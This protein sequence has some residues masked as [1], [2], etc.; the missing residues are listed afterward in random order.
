MTRHPTPR[1]HL[2]RMVSRGR[3]RFGRRDR[4]FARRRSS[5]MR[6]IVV[7]LSLS[8]FGLAN[9]VA[10]DAPKSRMPLVN[11]DEWHLIYF[12]AKPVGYVHRTVRA[13]RGGGYQVIDSQKPALRFVLDVV[14]SRVRSVEN[15]A[16]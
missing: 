15:R 7:A 10:D 3:G 6:H 1:S 14:A 2:E 8:S 16:A 12:G 4:S 5:G 13:R 11:Q 9:G